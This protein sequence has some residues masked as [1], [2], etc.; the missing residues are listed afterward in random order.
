MGR[1]ISIKGVVQ[2]EEHHFKML[3]VFDVWESG[4]TLK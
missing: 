1:I 2:I 4:Q 3:E